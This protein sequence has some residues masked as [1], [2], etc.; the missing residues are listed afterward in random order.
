MAIILGEVETLK[1]LRLDLY[2]FG[3]DFKSL[4]EIFL[5]KKDW[6]RRVEIAKDGCKE[7]LLQE[8]KES[9]R[10]LTDLKMEYQNK[11][12]DREDLLRKEKEEIKAELS[13]YSEIESNIFKKLYFAYRRISLSRRKD[14]LE[15]DFENEVKLPFGSYISSMSSMIDNINFKKNNIESITLE[16][17][18]PEIEKIKRAAIYLKEKEKLL[19]GAIGEQR[20]VEELK[21]LPD[22]YKVINDFQL[23]IHPPLHKKDEN[24][25]VDHICTIQIDHIVI[26]PPGVFIIETK[27][28]G[29]DSMENPNLFSPVAQLRRS[30]YALFIYLQNLHLQTFVSNWGKQKISL[31]NILLTMDSKPDTE[32]QHIKIL[33]LSEVIGYI[34]YFRPVFYENQV[35]EI[36][37]R[38]SSGKHSWYR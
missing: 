2:I 12:K 29:R 6:E 14:I 15:F 30:S 7:N 27:N 23:E 19:S 10:R 34:N 4:E 17:T 25:K 11:I 8:I 35:K 33:T 32:Y 20:A 24:G 28:W 9:E 36:S 31:K 38:L 13:R 1:Q 5:F 26:G 16:R 21:G 37:D 3:L 22:T 18:R